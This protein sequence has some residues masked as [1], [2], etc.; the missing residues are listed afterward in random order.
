MT[1][2][3]L[4]GGSNYA[5]FTIE[6]LEVANVTGCEQLGSRRSVRHLQVTSFDAMDLTMALQA[7][8]IENN[9]A[10]DWKGHIES[11][12]NDPDA[13]NQFISDV[14][15]NEEL[16]SFSMVQGLDVEVLVAA[17]ADVPSSS[18]IMTSSAP[19]ISNTGGGDAVP[20]GAPVTAAPTVNTGNFV[21]GAP[22]TA[23]DV[24]ADAGS[25]MAGVSSMNVMVSFY[26]GA[27]FVIV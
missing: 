23:N 6:S 8:M 27:L 26:L 13:V 5:P 18:P 11:R 20:S 4:V 24:S 21:T 15:S 12:F 1:A 22:I 2:G 3:F 17:E 16:G 9:G 14:T 19:I 7:E 25:N 10:D